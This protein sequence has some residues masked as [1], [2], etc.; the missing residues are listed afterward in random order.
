MNSCHE[1]AD[2]QVQLIELLE[3]ECF[4][5]IAYKESQVNQVCCIK[6]HI[7]QSNE[8]TQRHTQNMDFIKPTHYTVY[9]FNIVY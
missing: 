6:L 4:Q 5:I 9:T 3:F 1:M 2:I 7:L 8:I